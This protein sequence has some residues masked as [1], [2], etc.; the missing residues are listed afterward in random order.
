[1]AQGV[2]LSN[3]RSWRSVS[4]TKRFFRELRDRYPLNTPI[5]DPVDHSDLAALLERFDAAHPHEESK[6][7]VGIA[8]FEV[9]R[10]YDAPKPTDGFWVVR[11]D[12]S[13]TDFSF[14]WAAEGVPKPEAQ[15]FSD[16]CRQAVQ[17]DIEG[18]RQR[19]FAAYADAQ[20]RVQCPLDDVLIGSEDAHVD[21]VSPTFGALVISFRTSRGWHKAIPP[22]VL[23]RS[24]D[25]QLTTEFADAEI[26][27]AFKTFHSGIATLR[28]ISKHANL[29]RAA[30]Q[31]RQIGRP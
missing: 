26:R 21:H 6:I 14:I 5:D 23:T 12:D 17:R 18:Y 10:N 15:E 30:G 16:A 1:M 7:G 3:G 4:A 29:S 11:V 8:H 9:R 13:A 2:E 19:Y 31:R 22:G 25:N 24:T 20:G 28:I 27:E